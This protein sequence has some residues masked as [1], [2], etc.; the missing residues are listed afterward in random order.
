MPA[1]TTYF[2]L[3]WARTRTL[4]EVAYA[5]IT[6]RGPDGNLVGTVRDYFYPS[7]KKQWEGKLTRENPDTPTG[8]CT[9]WYEN[10]Q[11]S[12]RGTYAGGQQQADFK[13]W[14]WSK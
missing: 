3:D 12:F 6:R 4:E 1:D 13:R 8:L 7:W 14:R 9:G 11:L 5:R 10:G 2:D